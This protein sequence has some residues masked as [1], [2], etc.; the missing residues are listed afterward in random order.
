MD[1]TQWPCRDGVRDALKVARLDVFRIAVRILGRDLPLVQDSFTGNWIA[2]NTRRARLSLLL[3]GTGSA[4]D[5]VL[6]VGR[7][8]SGGG[9]GRAALDF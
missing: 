4:S 2:A 6:G 9:R 3:D 7:V 8:D 1:G 5:N